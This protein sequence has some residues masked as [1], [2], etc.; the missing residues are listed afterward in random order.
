VIAEFDD[1]EARVGY[2]AGV[3]TAGDPKL[4]SVLKPRTRG[5]SV[6]WVPSADLGELLAQEFED[7]EGEALSVLATSFGEMIGGGS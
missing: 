6:F 4:D 1:D 5:K 3:E 2:G 7:F